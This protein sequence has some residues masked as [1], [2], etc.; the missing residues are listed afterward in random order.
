MTKSVQISSS[1]YR[2]TRLL[3]LI[4]VSEASDDGGIGIE[5]Y[6]ASQFEDL[7]ERV[8][9]RLVDRHSIRRVV[10]HYLS[11]LNGKAPSRF[12]RAIKFFR[13]KALPTKVAVLST[14]R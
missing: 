14:A 2:T 10:H 8:A 3:G 13:P 1:T 11:L 12:E 7:K 4:R 5:D 6:Q 9:G